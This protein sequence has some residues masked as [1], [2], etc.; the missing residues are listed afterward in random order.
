MKQWMLSFT[1]FLSANLLFACGGWYPFGE[2]I[3]FSML[4]PQMFDDGGM[5]PFYYSADYISGYY[6][7]EWSSDR[8][9]DD[10]YAFT[11]GKVK[12]EDIFDGVYRLTS[13]EILN[14]K[15]KHPFVVQMRAQGSIDE[16][17]YLAFAKRYSHLNSTWSDPWERE[18]KSVRKKRER[19]IEKALKLAQSASSETLKRRYAF[20]ALRLAFYNEDYSKVA[21]LYGKYFNGKDEMII[22]KWA[23]FFFLHYEPNTAETNFK[24]AQLFPEIPSKRF[25]IFTLFKWDLEQSETLAFAKTNEEKANVLAMYAIRRLDKTLNTL[26]EIYRLDPENELLPFLLVRELNKVEDWV[27][28]P[29]YTSYAPVLRPGLDTYT[30]DQQLIREAA[31]DDRKYAAELLAWLDVHG[32]KLDAELFHSVKAML[33]FCVGNPSGARATLAKSSFEKEDREAWRLRMMDLMK[34]VAGAPLTDLNLDL[35]LEK[36]FTYK[37]RLIF[38]LGRTLEYRDD[39]NNALLLFAQLNKDTDYWYGFTWAETRGLTRYNLSHYFDYFDYFDANY[40]AKELGEALKYAEKIKSSDA[41]AGMKEMAEFVWQDELR[42]KDLIGTKYFREDQMEAALLWLKQ[43][44]E[45]YWKAD[46]NHYD[47][48]LAANPFYANFY[49]EHAPTPG[50]T[51]SFT[52]YEIAYKLNQMLESY[53]NQKGNEKARTLYHIAN[54]YFNMTTY[55]NSWMMRRSWWSSYVANTVYVDSDE[56]T[57]CLKAK[58]YFMKAYK[59]AESGKFKALCL[60][61]AGRCEGYQLLAEEEYDYEMDYDKYGGYYEYLFQKNSTYK[62]L[63]NEFPEFER[64]LISNC[65]SFNRFYRSI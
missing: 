10:W 43:L 4:H 14:A 15:S 56:Y 57:R 54:C 39:L 25:G 48:Y 65:Y 44:P 34:L 45:S 11:Q 12:K 2:N 55:G 61:M 26:D 47:F 31:E 53:P 7:H 63:K 30:E 36:D 58:E 3:R 50:D 28:A 35:F 38:M 5:A 16:L 19:A 22:D 60:R 62:R 41:P 13:Q 23:T 52:K 18:G 6:N 33:Q 42:L 46:E 29:A 37:D 24:L 27:L 1:F 8:N 51:V 21:G 40:S 59:A 20:Q 64:E 49:S 9:V 17:E 32:N